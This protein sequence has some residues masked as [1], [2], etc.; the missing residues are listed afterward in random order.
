MQ[1][2]PLRRDDGL[3]G[4]VK[5]GL[6]EQFKRLFKVG[7]LLF[8]PPRQQGG[9][10]F[11]QRVGQLAGR[12]GAFALGEHHLLEMLEIPAADAAGKA[13]DAGLRDMQRRGQF[14]DGHKQELVPMGA[15]V[16]QNRTLGGS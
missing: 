11:G 15:D 7:P 13:G 16:F 6:V 9:L 5:L 4:A 1:I 3:H 10:A 2:D 14:G 12:T 8:D